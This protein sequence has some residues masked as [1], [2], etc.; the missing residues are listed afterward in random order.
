[1]K[2]VVFVE[3][4]TT[5]TGRM[6]VDRLLAG[7]H[8]VTF[9][10]RNRANYPFTSSSSPR[11]DVVDGETN[12]AGAV[13]A[14]VRQIG[15]RRPVD[16]LLTFSEFYV[17]AVA[18]V[19]AT[20]GFPALAPHTAATCRNKYLTRRCLQAAGLATPGFWLVSAEREARRVAGHVAYPCIVKPPAD[21][22]SHGVRLVHNR[23]ELLSHYRALSVCKEN[24]RGQRLDG[25]VLIETLLDGP[26]FSV[27]TF[28]R[29]GGHTEVIGVTDKHLGTPPH[30]VEIG[31]DFPSAATDEVKNGLAIA[32]RKALEAVGFNFGPAHTEIRWT[33]DG[34][35]VVE[36][37]PR[38]AGGMIPELVCYA[39][40]IDLLGAWLS[41]ALNEPIDLTPRWDAT[42]SIR[43]LIADRLGTILRVTGVDETR[44]LPMI[45]D[46][47]IGRGSGAAVRPAEDAYDR[48]GFVIAAGADRRSVRRS[49]DRALSSITFHIAA[50]DE[51]VVA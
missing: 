19:A 34:P 29:P 28:T 32:V 21:S 17:S 18:E 24:V 14:H 42:A 50:P 6:A 48:L 3:S 23:N 22:S 31:H 25:R 47:S 7:G 8:R 39:T 15:Q 1:V 49:L 30:F 38:L 33:C 37:N 10:T 41:L 35:A 5:G 46:V 13:L 44:A 40:G 26:E 16:A 2:H 20:L 12:D 11:L 51:Q 27:E 36:I 9:L 4:N 43:F 45:R